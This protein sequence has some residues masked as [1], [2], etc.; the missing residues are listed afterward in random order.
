MNN[1]A[2]FWII[3]NISIL[4]LLVLDLFVFNKG[5]KVVTTKSALIW[6]AFWVGL[7]MAFNVFVY[8]WKGREAAE[9]FFTGYVIEE[10]LSV[11]NLFVFML[12]F[13][14]FRVPS[15]YQ[16][17]VLFWGI[18]GALVL[19]GLF[20]VLGIELIERFDWLLYVLGFF[21]MYTGIKM[22]FSSD[23]DEIDPENNIILKLTNK[24]IRVTKNYEEDK[25]FIRKDGI[26]YATPL[27]IVVLIVE[28]TDVVFAVDS[29]PTI[30][31]ITTDTFIVYTS[32]VFALLGLR[33][34]YFALSSVMKLFH[35]INYGLAIILSFVGIKLLIHH[36][37]VIDHQFALLFVVSTLAISVLASWLFPK[38]NTENLD[39]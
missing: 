3:F 23:D 30:L 33:S 17:K 15:E 4:S 34:L 36:W 6:S 5:N 35:Y 39:F 25:F 7:A 11:D 27:F 8:F 32:N 2:S 26:L 14:Y 38:K 16:R 9:L 19:R 12:I 28:S 18:I 31:G 22:L 21:L 20:I 10:S 29:I 24:F 1:E 37:Y 13:S